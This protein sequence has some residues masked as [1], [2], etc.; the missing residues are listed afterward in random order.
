MSWIIPILYGTTVF[1]YVAHTVINILSRRRM[2]WTSVLIL[3]LPLTTVYYS[4]Y[5]GNDEYTQARCK[6]W[7]PTADELGLIAD[8]SSRL[9]H[10]RFAGDLFSFRSQGSRLLS[11]PLRSSNQV[12]IIPAHPNNVPCLSESLL[13]ISVQI[14]RRKYINFIITQLIA[15]ID[16]VRCL[17]LCVSPPTLYIYIN[18]Q[19][20]PSMCS[21]HV[22]QV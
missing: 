16:S 12:V 13:V 17:K 22:K 14:G 8:Q 21:T 10:G 18:D 6:T 1:I 3:L 9:F 5:P 15:C 7:K 4:W 2:A 19:F 20:D 11:T